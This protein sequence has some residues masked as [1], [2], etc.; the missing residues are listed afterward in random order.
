MIVLVDAVVDAVLEGLDAVDP[1]GMKNL[2][3]SK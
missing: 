2:D 3:L 1:V